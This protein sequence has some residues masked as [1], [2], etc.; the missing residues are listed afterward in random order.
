MLMAGS[1]GVG[2]VCYSALLWT[3]L[4]NTAMPGVRL[5]RLSKGMHSG[6]GEL[7]GPGAQG[8]SGWTHRNQSHQHVNSWG[9]PSCRVCTERHPDS[10]PCRA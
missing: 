3:L 5:G 9:R 1:L 10:Q 8:R 6:W 7:Y 2:V 4:T